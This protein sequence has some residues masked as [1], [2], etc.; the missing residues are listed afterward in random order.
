M[1]SHNAVTFPAALRGIG[2][3]LEESGLLSEYPDEARRLIETELTD[4]L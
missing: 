3:Y 4:A 1:V 2:A